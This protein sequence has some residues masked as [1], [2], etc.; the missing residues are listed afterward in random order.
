M[1][2]IFS[3]GIV[4]VV[5]FRIGTYS[6]YRVSLSYWRYMAH[7][8]LTYSGL[9]TSNY[10]NL[11]RDLSWM[12][13]KNHEHSD[14]NG[15]VLG[16][17]CNIKIH[18]DTAGSITFGTAPNT[19]KMRNAFRKWHAYRDLMFEEA[20]VSESEKGRYAKTIRPFL[21]TEAYD[22][23]KTPV[24]WDVSGTPPTQTQEW[25]Q[26]QIAASPGFGATGGTGTGGEEIVD[27]YDLSICGT[28]VVAKTSS[29]GAQY[30]TRVGMIHSYNQD[31]QEVVTPTLDSQTVEGQNNPLALLR[32]GGSVSGGEVMDIVEDQELEAP[33]YDITDNGWST[34]GV[35]SDIMQINPGYDGTNSVPVLR[36]TTV[37]VPAGLLNIS[38]SVAMSSAALLIDVVGIVLCKDME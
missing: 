36:Q 26:T 17:L 16:Y 24:G 5:C 9:G 27:V 30:Y 6:L 21:S 22:D 23:Y 15:H 4:F 13:S 28:N 35:V 14:R 37:F 10:Y 25:T 34:N 31:R 19:W 11:T 8:I 7:N 20:G 3:I 18:S 29:I 2:I 38:S 33:P 1:P 12:N 32:Q